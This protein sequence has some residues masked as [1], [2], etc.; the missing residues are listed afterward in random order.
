M[1]LTPISK[2]CRFVLQ[3]MFQLNI[4]L[5][6]YFTT[7]LLQVTALLVAQVVKNLPA[8]SIPGLGGPPG[9]GNSYPFQTS[10]LENSMDRGA[11]QALPCG[12]AES[13]T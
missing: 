1:P 13:Q 12:I 6:I 5:L 8:D 7:T 11:R 10:C 3:T 2:C 4:F 9:E